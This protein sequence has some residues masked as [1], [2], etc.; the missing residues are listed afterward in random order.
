[1]ILIFIL[2]FILVTLVTLMHFEGLTFIA[3]YALRHHWQLERWHLVLTIL[4][5][6]GLHLLEICV[7][8]IGT[9]IAHHVLHLGSFSGDREFALIDYFHFSAETFVTVGYG[10][11]YPVGP[12]R[13]LTGIESLTGV[14]L[15]AWSG[16]FSF[17][18]VQK[19]WESRIKRP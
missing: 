2:S 7:F 16:A 12:L 8:S 5:I 6:M 19:L 17:F 15:I 10:D 9:F 4:L 3:R 1:M 14:L 13:V 18:T 11:L